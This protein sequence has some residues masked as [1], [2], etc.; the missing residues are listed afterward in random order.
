M[1][2]TPLPTRRPSSSGTVNVSG[3]SGSVIATSGTSGTGFMLNN[4]TFNVAST[5]VIP[6]LTVSAPLTYSQAGTT[7]GTLTK[8]GAGT[9]LLS[10]ANTYTGGTTIN[11]GVISISAD[12]NLGASSG[13][14]TLNGGQLTDSSNSVITNTHAWNVAANGGTIN[15]AG[16]AQYYFNTTNALVGSGPLTVT[17]TGNLASNGAGNLRVD[18]TN[19]YSGNMTLQNGGI[20]EYGTQNAFPAAATFTVNNQGELALQGGGVTTLSSSITVNGNTNSVLSFENSGSLG[21][22]AGTITLSARR[23]C[24]HRTPRLVQQQHRA[25]RHHQRPDHRQRQHDRQLGQ[26]RR[27]R[28]H[29]HQL[30]QQLQRRHH[31]QQRHAAERRGRKQRPVGAISPF[32]SGTITV[33]SGG[34]LEL[35]TNVGTHNNTEFDFSNGVTLNNGTVYEY[36]G[37]QHIKGTVTVN[38]GGGTL[39]S[40][41]NTGS[42]DGNKGLFLDGIV[43]GS[44]PL[45]LRQSGFN[46]GNSYNTSIV[47]F[48]NN[49]NSYS[50]TITVVPM[51]GTAGGSYLG[52][53]GSNVLALATVNLPGNNT[54]SSQQFGTSPLVF[55]NALSSGTLGAL[56]GSANVVLTVYDEGSHTYGGAFALG[57]GNNNTST[58]YSGVMSGGGSLTKLGTGTFTL[59]GNDTYTGGTSI[60]A[61]ALNLSGSLTGGGTIAVSPAATFTEA[62]A[63]LISGGAALTNSGATFLAA[64]NTFTGG[65]Q[66]GGGTVNINADAALG[67]VPTSTST[68]NV[69]FTGNGALQFAAGFT[70]SASRTIALNNGVM[71]ILDTQ[72]FTATIPGVITSAGSLDKI[73]AGTLVLSGSSNFSGAA[74]VNAGVLQLPAGGVLA[75]ASAINV[76]AGMLKLTGGTISSNGAVNVASGATL[77]AT[78]S[79]GNTIA[80]PVAEAG[81]GTIDLSTGLVTT[82]VLNLNGGLTVGGNSAGNPSYLNFV[83]AP[84]GSA[85]DTINLGSGTLTGNAGGAVI[86]IGTLSLNNATYTLLNY[87]GVTGLTPSGNLTVGTQP[88]QF[89]TRFTLSLSNTTGAALAAHRGRNPLLQRG[90]LDAR[91]GHARTELERQRRHLPDELGQGRRRLDP[92]RT[93]PRPGHRRD[94]CRQ[95]HLQRLA[96]HQPRRA[97]LDQQPDHRRHGAAAEARRPSAA[98]AP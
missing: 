62:A 85:A 16:A 76:N 2:I 73:G 1:A 44:G 67:A 96:R 46:T 36:D 55:S 78:G 22:Y 75:S 89:A 6:D 7:G 64:S 27:R 63:G 87:G 68:A 41:Y 9:M 54:S 12:N 51:S 28:A 26:R 20:L 8:T 58:T 10:G 49:A 52:L 82:N 91:R 53:N 47:Y 11:A 3:G 98:P 39:G 80:G 37:I 72:G 31:H 92:H 65:T 25:Q 33:N 57:V 19:T 95:Q 93:V 56:T 86:N 32:G 45:T 60:S 13:T 70:L 5:G 74:A 35:G 38:A 29:G 77:V 61:G 40:T 15:I 50:G 69:T 4:V 66:I 84:T 83:L 79:S 17:G 90:L 43:S 97:L 48:S 30:G 42:S 59:S 14:V 23:Q 21:S 71:G 18:H 81:N 24:H 34:L 94:L 88:T